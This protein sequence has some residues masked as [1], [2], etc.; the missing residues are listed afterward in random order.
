MVFCVAPLVSTGAAFVCSYSH[1]FGSQ[2]ICSDE[3][4][5]R[6]NRLDWIT[7]WNNPFISQSVQLSS[8]S[9][10]SHPAGICFPSPG[11]SLRGER[12]MSNDSITDHDTVE[13]EPRVIDSRWVTQ[14]RLSP[15]PAL[16]H[17]LEV[18]S[19]KHHTLSFDNCRE[20]YSTCWSKLAAFSLQKVFVFQTL[21]DSHL[22]WT[23]RPRAQFRWVR[24]RS[25]TGCG[26]RARH[27]TENWVLHC[28]VSIQCKWI[29]KWHENILLWR[30]ALCCNRDKAGVW[31]MTAGLMMYSV[32]GLYSRRSFWPFI[33]LSPLP[34]T[35]ITSRNESCAS[36]QSALLWNWLGGIF[37]S[38]H[39]TS[40]PFLSLFFFCLFPLPH[41]PSPV[42]L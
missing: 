38:P 42:F 30:C 25:R 21:A 11:P 17:V 13:S 39:L 37:S 7:P 4:I 36:W 22:N 1:V 9:I 23:F 15:S 2:T 35:V 5:F 19:R 24:L 6:V 12:C 32:A 18:Q 26:E 28:W 40:F 20:A 10:E 41:C 29:L 8:P 27:Q 34:V 16:R 14:A 31:A 3:Q 33:S